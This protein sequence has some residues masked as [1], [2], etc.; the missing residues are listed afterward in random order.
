VNEPALRAW[1]LGGSWVTIAFAESLYP[2]FAMA[3]A[4]YKLTD[5]AFLVI[6]RD[7]SDLLVTIRPKAEANLE[8]LVGALMN[9]ALDQA[10]RASLAA[11][12]GS[13]QQIIVEEALRPGRA[14]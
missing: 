10:V 12:F 14:R 7:G 4:A 11:E 1:T 3:R 5:R 9:E 8:E 2:A 13:L 6:T